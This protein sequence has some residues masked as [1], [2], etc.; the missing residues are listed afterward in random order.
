MSD[1]VDRLRE[2]V[3]TKPV[4]LWQKN[5]LD[6]ATEIERL[7]SALKNIERESYE[8]EI[9]RLVREALETGARS[10]L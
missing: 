4:M 8:P 3:G 6:A 5:Y 7:R 2:D 9:T 1:I 10:G